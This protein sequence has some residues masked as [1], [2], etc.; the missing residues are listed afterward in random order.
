MNEP[1]LF[2]EMLTTYPAE[3]RELA[4]QV[5]HRFADG[6]STQF[7]S[8][9]LLVLDVYAHYAERIP[10]R[11]ISANAD[12][13]A[14]A[15]EIRGEIA[16]IARAIKERDVNITNHAEQTDELCRLT[17]ARCNEAVAKIESLVK[18]LGT[19]VDTKAI[20]RG[21][22]AALDTGIKSEIIWPFIKHSNELGNQVLPALKEIKEASS[23]AL[24]L[25][26]Q[27]IWKTAWAGSL[28]V[29]FTLF[30]VATTGI[31]NAFDHY[32]ERK[33]AEKI[34]ETSQLMAY[35]QEAFRQLAVAQIPIRLERVAN[36]DGSVISQKFAVAI[37]DADSAEMRDED[38]HH[39]CLVFV[40]SHSTEDQIQQTQQ[41]IK[42]LL[43]TG[44]AK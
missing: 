12:S 31:Y 15:E 39:N 1:S 9:L 36:N 14:T 42:K 5:Y 13:L 29:T 43:Q 34:A 18:N 27:H 2:E 35:N 7:F 28:L 26:K 44:G 33:D 4:R 21:I 8:Q 22:Q 25:W 3:K 38:G 30:T 32:A 17:Q 11:M 24:T 37:Q 16:H 10:A 20:V 40:T 19:Q 23:E 6:D 41:E